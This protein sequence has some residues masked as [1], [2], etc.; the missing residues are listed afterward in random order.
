MKERPPLILRS[1]G[2]YFINNKVSRP[3]HEI[4]G[5]L[6]SKDDKVTRLETL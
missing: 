3:T 2:F 5:C 1:G 4:D 6:W